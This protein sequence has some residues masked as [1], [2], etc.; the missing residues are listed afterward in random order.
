[1]IIMDFMEIEKF[2]ARN[3]G[4]HS[5][6]TVTRFIQYA[7]TFICCEH[8]LVQNFTSASSMC[9]LNSTG[10]T[11][12]HDSVWFFEVL[13]IR[14]IFRYVLRLNFQLISWICEGFHLFSVPHLHQFWRMTRGRTRE[15][16]PWL[17]PKHLIYF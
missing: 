7:D 16:Y 11:I 4:E 8:G 9:Y 17:F 5:F 14:C 3:L 1:M 6:P 13:G 15:Q 12:D 2:S 10:H